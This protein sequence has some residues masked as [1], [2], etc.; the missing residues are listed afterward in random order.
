MSRNSYSRKGSRSNKRGN[1]SRKYT[2]FGYTLGR[3]MSASKDSRV[4]QAVQ[5]GASAAKDGG[6]ERP[7]F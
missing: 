2:D 1:S 3:V 4:G 6:K 7:L 5:R